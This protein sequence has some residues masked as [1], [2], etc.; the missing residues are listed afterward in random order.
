M[1][2][3]HLKQLGITYNACGVL[4]KNRKTKQKSKGFII[5]LL[6]R[7]RQKLAFH[8]IWLMEILRIYLKEHLLINNCVIRYLVLLRIRNMM[9]IKQVS[10]QM[11]VNFLIK[12][13][14][15]IGLKVKL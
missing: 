3:M 15:V 7:I 6:K 13:L 9:D 1:P 2:Q 8:M 12:S 5:H 11:Y 14:Q 4:A 10:L